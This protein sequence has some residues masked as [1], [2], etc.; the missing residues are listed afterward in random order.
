MPQS[1]SRER[2]WATRTRSTARL[3]IVR[4]PRTPRR[5]P[6]IRRGC[7]LSLVAECI[8]R[9]RTAFCESRTH[10]YAVFPLDVSVAIACAPQLKSMTSSRCSTALLTRWTR[11]PA[12][13]SSRASSSRPASAPPPSGYA[14][15]PECARDTGVFAAL[16]CLCFR[17][18]FHMDS[19]FVFYGIGHAPRRLPPAAR[20]LLPA[21]LP[22]RPCL[23]RACSTC[24]TCS[25]AA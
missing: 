5:P 2:E 11:K 21:C 7:V 12:S 18:P 17:C 16:V 15:R 19:F 23:G 13:A 25:G 9:G 8:A 1:A 22:A 6:F 4:I 24:S 14:Q 20:R 3:L 10:A